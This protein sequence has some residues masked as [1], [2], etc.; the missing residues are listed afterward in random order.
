MRKKFAIGEYVVI[1]TLG[2]GLG[3]TGQSRRG[4]RII[5]IHHNMKGEICGYRVEVDVRENGR[6][7]MRIADVE[8][9]RI[10]GRIKEEL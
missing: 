1:V 5:A 7:V 4:G 6:R 2:T 10:S 8:P 3:I 9:D